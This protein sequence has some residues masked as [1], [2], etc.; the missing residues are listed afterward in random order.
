MTD[1]GIYLPQ[2]NA[3]FVVDQE[4]REERRVNSLPAPFFCMMTQ[5][6]TYLK[7]FCRDTNRLMQF[8]RQLDVH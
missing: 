6:T 3:C 2:R 5:V 1:G 7:G 8:S 4:N